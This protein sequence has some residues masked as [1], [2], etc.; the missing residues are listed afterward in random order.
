M[1]L[2]RHASKH[3]KWES[4]WSCWWA[5]ALLPGFVYHEVDGEQWWVSL[6]E[7]GYTA[8]VSWPVG[9]VKHGSTVCYRLQEAS[10]VQALKLGIVLE[11][12]TIEVQ[13]CKWLSPLHLLVE[14][15]PI[16]MGVCLAAQ[17]GPVPLD[18]ALALKGFGDL[19]LPTLKA[20]CKWYSLD[21]AG[22]LFDVVH[23]LS[24][25]ILGEEFVGSPEG[26]EVLE[27]RL[28]NT[29]MDFD[30]SFLEESNMQEVLEEDE[31]KER[32]A[33]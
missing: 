16:D 24:C 21:I 23:R 15:H 14:G 12:A 22:S 20:M 5:A 32:E 33:F 30:F 25:H 28:R 7:V 29:D 13:P 11:P 1:E 10:D 31:R 8:A 18:K 4:S 17:G 6:G 2:M 3:D 27:T 26:V 19:Q 9:V